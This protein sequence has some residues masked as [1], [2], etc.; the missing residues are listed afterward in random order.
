MPC[1]MHTHIYSTYMH[2]CN[3]RTCERLKKSLLVSKQ[4]DFHLVY[5]AIKSFIA[6]LDV[7]WTNTFYFWMVHTRYKQTSKY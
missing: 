6:I 5:D 2:L 4:N 3:S 1:Y 7:T